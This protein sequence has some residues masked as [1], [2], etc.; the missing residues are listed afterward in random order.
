MPPPPAPLPLTV[1]PELEL[2]ELVAELALVPHVVAEVEIARHGPATAAAERPGV[3]RGGA[4]EGRHGGAEL[5]SLPAPLGRQR[6]PPPPA[7]AAT[8]AVAAAPWRAPVAAAGPPLPLFAAGE[9]QGP[10]PKLKRGRPGHRRVPE[11]AVQVRGAASPSPSP[12]RRPPSSGQRLG[13]SAGGSPGVRAV[14]S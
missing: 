11:R 3:Q 4:G 8:A 10:Q 2:E 5:A 13:P 7:G 14:F 1:G 9:G 6:R 12:P